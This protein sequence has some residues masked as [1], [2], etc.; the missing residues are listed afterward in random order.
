MTHGDP[1]MHAIDVASK[2]NVGYSLEWLRRNGIDSVLRYISRSDS[3]KC[4]DAAELRTL[5]DAG[6]TVG[7]I[8]EMDGGSPEFGGLAASINATFGEYDGAYA[9]RTLQALGVPQGAVVY[10]AVDTDVNNNHDINTYV[11]PY[12]QAAKQALAGTYRIGAYSCGATCAAAL[13]TAGCDKAWLANAPDWTAYRQFLDEGRAAIVQG[14]GPNMADYDPDFIRD[15]DW[16]GFN[17][18]DA[19]AVA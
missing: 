10:F 12:F 5:I 1:R 15:A 11:I 18:L 7:I 14:K 3:A 19:A 4:I 8:Y 16:G 9:L 13:D 17:A 6:I 2:L